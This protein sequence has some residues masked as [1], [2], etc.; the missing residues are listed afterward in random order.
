MNHSFVLQQRVPPLRPLPEAQCP[1]NRVKLCISTGK[2][3]QLLRN[4]TLH[5]E[6]LRCTDRHSQCVLKRLLLGC[7][8]CNVEEQP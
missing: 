4:G 1:A 6:D 2:L 3:Y 5:A 7:C 8:L